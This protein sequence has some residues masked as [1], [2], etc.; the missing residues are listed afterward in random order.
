[1]VALQEV[2]SNADFERLVKLMPGWRGYLNP[3]NNDAWNLAYLFKSSEIEV[4]SSSES[5][6][7]KE[8]IFAFPRAPY[9]IKVRHKPSGKEL[10]LINIHLKCCRGPDN[11]NSRRSASLKLKNY[12]DSSRT[13]NRIVVLGDFN[14]EIS[15]DSESENPFLNFANDTVDYKFA[16]MPIAR[17]SPLWWSY[18]SFPSHIDHILV[19]GELATSIDTCFVVKASP[20]YPDYAANLS[21]H[22][23]VEIQLIFER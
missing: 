10:F 13:N 15:S 14:D 7:F 21:D 18:P 4:I 12:L 16:D 22:R 23:P 11:E 3:V 9:E 1:V 5:L 20:C 19:S 17:G 8:D 2:A 6:L